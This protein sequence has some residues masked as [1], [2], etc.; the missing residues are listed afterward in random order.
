MAIVFNALSEDLGGFREKIDPGALTRT[1][2][3]NPD[4]RALHEHQAARILGRTTAGTLDLRIEQQGLRALID[5]SDAPTA[6]D[7]GAAVSRRDVRGMSFAFVG[8]E[9]DW[10]VVDKQLER[11]IVGLHLLEVSA[12]G[13]PAYPQTSISARSLDGKEADE[14]IGDRA[15]RIRAIRERWCEPVASGGAMEGEAMQTRHVGLGEVERAALAIE[16]RR[17]N[18][19]ATFQRGL[20]VVGRRLL[21]ERDRERRAGRRVQDVSDLSDVEL[22]ALHAAMDEET[23]RYRDGRI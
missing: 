12:V 10:R 1:L 19:N 20:L 14:T 6:T 23:A 4:I 3:E 21:E 5:L 2:R 11:T 7:V 9:D 8:A 17:V 13:D 18:R 16:G 15:E 22:R